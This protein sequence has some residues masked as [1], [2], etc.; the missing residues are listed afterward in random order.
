MQLVIH[1]PDDFIEPVKSKLENG[2]TGV[3]EAIAL[4]AILGYLDRLHEA[5]ES[6]DAIE[7]QLGGSG[8]RHAL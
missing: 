1:V 3:L 8:K 7:R 4:D 5:E 2:P 6:L